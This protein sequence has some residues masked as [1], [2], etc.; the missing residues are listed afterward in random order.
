[1]AIPL[2]AGRDFGPGDTNRSMPVAVV[3]ELF[4]RSLF[5]GKDPLGGRIRVV[6][7]R[8]EPDRVYQIVGLVGDTKYLDIHEDIP[9]TVYLAEGQDPQPGA[10]VRIMI[11]SDG[12][13][14]SVVSGVKQT[15]SEVNPSIILELQVLRSSVLDS[16]LRE[17]LLATLSGFFGLLAVLLACVGLY[18]VISYGVTTR[19]GEIG[20]RLALGAEP[21]DVISMVLREAFI[22]VGLG[23][24]IGIPVVIGGNRMLES[25]LYNAKSIDIGLI[26]LGAIVLIAVAMIAAYVPARRASR[27]DPMNALRYE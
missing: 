12:S 19:T 26:G 17:R 23:V 3:G 11:H 15:A 25:L 21:H 7:G 4:A 6:G 1:M 18:G 8:G 13:L 10:G 5:N 14:A 24:L 22:L 2:L 20:V 9:A 27:T 16:L